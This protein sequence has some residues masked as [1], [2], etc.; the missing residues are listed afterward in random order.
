MAKKAK[1]SKIKVKDL[2]AKKDP[3]GGLA[4]FKFKGPGISAHKVST[5]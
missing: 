1:S 4:A 2:K 3:K 5:S